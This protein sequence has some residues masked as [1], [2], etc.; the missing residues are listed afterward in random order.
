M[1]TRDEKVAAHLA[2]RLVLLK[3]KPTKEEWM[4]M[5]KKAETVVDNLTQGQNVLTADEVPHHAYTVAMNRR[6]H[7]HACMVAAQTV[8]EIDWK[9]TKADWTSLKA[10]DDGETMFVSVR[11]AIPKTEYERVKRQYIRLQLAR[12]VKAAK[13]EAK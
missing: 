10:G 6:A 13:G 1:K 12:A 7:R 2:N 9:Y 3:T 11:M 8:G 5:T 4:K